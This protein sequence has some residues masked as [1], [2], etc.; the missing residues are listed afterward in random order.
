MN[1]FETESN[2]LQM[3]RKI[4]AEILTGHVQSNLE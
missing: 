2:Y 1:L 3:D 4:L